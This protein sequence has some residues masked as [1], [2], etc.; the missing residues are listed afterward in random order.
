M[1][2]L[3]KRCGRKQVGKTAKKQLKRIAYSVKTFLV[4]LAFAML[5]IV[6]NQSWRAVELIDAYK[7]SVENNIENDLKLANLSVDNYFDSILS[8]LTAVTTRNDI[9]QMEDWKAS[10]ELRKMSANTNGISVLYMMDNEGTIKS[11]KNAEYQVLSPPIVKEMALMAS[12]MPG[13]TQYSQPYYSTMTGS[14]AFCVSYSSGDRTA[15]VELGNRYLHNMMQQI[16]GGTGRLFA[17]KAGENISFLFSEFIDLD[18]VKKNSYPFELTDEVASVMSEAGE[19]MTLSQIT[20]FPDYYMMYSSRNMQGWEIYSFY[21]SGILGAYEKEIWLGVLMTT[22]LLLGV[23]FVISFFVSFLLT[24]P[25]RRL[26]GEMETIKDLN[27]LIEMNYGADGEFAYLINSYNHLIL[28]IR[29]LVDDVQETERKKLEYEF[30][31]LQNQIGPHFLHN[32]LACV[33]SLMRQK[34]YEPAQEAQRALIRLL[35]YTFEMNE[36]PVTLQQE[37]EQLQNYV[38]IEKIRYG[39]CFTFTVCMEEE[40]ETVG[41][42]KLTLQPLVENAIFHGL[43]PKGGEGGELKVIARVRRGVLHIFITDNG[44]GMSKQLCRNALSGERASRITDRL[45]SVGMSNV[46]E[47]LKLRY[48]R[49][50]GIWMKSEEGKGTVVCLRMPAERNKT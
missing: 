10:R 32:T 22:G 37:I 48:G 43:I 42:L 3:L 26:A 40:A 41:I 49:Q 25:V 47:R 1:E 24:R 33:L 31:M 11:G 38:M 15:I 34:K 44:I 46:K 2:S 5:I 45:S 29:S 21:E 16:L 8:L 9:E 28:K 23:L 14:Y 50:Y 12:A 19:E 20:Q 4:L 18:M 30:R 17:V 7:Q 27:Q 36:A 13:F 6:L 39:D 35:S